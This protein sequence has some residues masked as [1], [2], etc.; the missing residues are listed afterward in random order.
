M[1]EMVG[2]T[3]KVISVDIQAEMLKRKS[4]QLGWDRV[5]SFINPNQMR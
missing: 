5:L 4:E 1:A 3:G 2:E